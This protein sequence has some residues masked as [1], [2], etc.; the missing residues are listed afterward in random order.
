MIR[1][2]YTLILF[3]LAY[4]SYAWNALGH[5]LVAQIAYDHLTPQAKKMCEDYNHYLDSF[6]PSPNFVTASAWLDQ[7]RRNDVHWFDNLHYIDIPFSND[8]SKL[9]PLQEVNALWG[10]KQAI[11]VLSSN[12][13]SAFD[14]G[15]S[16][17]ILTH[18]IGDIHQ[19]LH[20][21]TKV[22]KR[23]PKGDLGGNLYYLTSNSIGDNLHQYWDN[24][25]GV[26]LGQSKKFQVR[27]KALQ[28]EQKW[29]CELANAQ[30]K[31]QQWIK[32]SHQLAITQVYTIPSHKVPS[33]RYQLKAQNI[34]Q[35]QIL[36]AGCRL[37]RVL[38]NIARQQH[39]S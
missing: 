38:N 35:K 27:N 23:L 7:I 10:I 12:K 17:R 26:L 1:I 20:T 32:E 25:A 22:S 33:K 39:Y 31:P 19:P 2:I 8:Q 6:S 18:L 5:Q 34:T 30:K 9:P 4:N 24:G 3:F 14:K 11:L 13:S 29:S 36:F 16:L 28:L 21:V 37:A 15:I